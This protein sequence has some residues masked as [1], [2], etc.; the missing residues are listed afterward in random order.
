MLLTAPSSSCCQRSRPTSFQALRMVDQQQYTTFWGACTVRGLLE[1]EAHWNATLEEAAVS[2]LPH[3]LRSL[4]AIMIVACELG[5]PTHL[6][7][8]YKESL[9]DVLLQACR[10]NPRQEM[11]F[12]DAIFNEALILLEDKVIALG[13][14]E[15]PN[16]G[17]PTPAPR[18]R[19]STSRNH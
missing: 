11:H 3:M 7:D 4:F 17:L 10:M 5:N 12:N 14:Q 1:D 13:S 9:A 6:W 19:I 15:L 18:P 8:S 2:H 16:Y